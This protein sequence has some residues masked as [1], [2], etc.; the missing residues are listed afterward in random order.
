MWGGPVGGRLRLR[1]RWFEF[2]WRHVVIRLSFLSY[3]HVCNVRSRQHTSPTLSQCGGLRTPQRRPGPTVGRIMCLCLLLLIVS[4]AYPIL[5]R[6][7]TYPCRSPHQ[8]P[9]LN[10]QECRSMRISGTHTAFMM[11]YCI[12][13]DLGGPTVCTVD[14]G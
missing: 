2:V 10:P 13:D 8:Q 1:G 4:L 5:L 11:L 3:V 12:I 9:A 14:V 7:S 6:P